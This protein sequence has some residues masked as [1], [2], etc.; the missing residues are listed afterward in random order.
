M[1]SDPSPLKYMG[2]QSQE[3]LNVAAAMAH[4]PARSASPAADQAIGMPAD[5]LGEVSA[6]G[7]RIGDAAHWAM[8]KAKDTL[9]SAAEQVREQA[10]TAV[11]TYTRE[12]P[13][14]AIVIAAA[15]GALLMGLVVMMARSGARTVGRSV[16]R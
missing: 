6:A 4:D 9:Q 2:T 16:T 14:R 1:S 15:A 5:E 8:G 3:T 13:L 7:S 11:A 10:T 12:Q